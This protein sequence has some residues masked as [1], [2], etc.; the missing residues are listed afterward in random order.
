[1]SKRTTARANALA[2]QRV[3]ES[4]ARTGDEVER[5]IDGAAAHVDLRGGRMRTAP[6]DVTRTPE[7]IAVRPV[8]HVPTGT[9]SENHYRV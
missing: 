1:M 8:G 3:D 6:E 2:M 5:V 7:T 9:T 4:D